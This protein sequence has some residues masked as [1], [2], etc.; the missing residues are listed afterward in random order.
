MRTF[1]GNTLVRK[2]N[3]RAFFHHLSFCIED[4]RGFLYRTVLNM[5]TAQSI[6]LL[7]RAGYLYKFDAF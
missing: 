3:V 5:L 7:L 1:P 6:R 4:N 2:K